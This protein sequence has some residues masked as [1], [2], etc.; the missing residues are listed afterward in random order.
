MTLSGFAYLWFAL[1]VGCILAGMVLTGKR[2]EKEPPR[3]RLVRRIEQRPRHLVDRS[4]QAGDACTRCAQPLESGA[5]FCGACGLALPD[6]RR[7]HSERE[8]LTRQA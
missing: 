6:R 3:E 7:A 2:L 8:R 4:Q 1:A 5:R